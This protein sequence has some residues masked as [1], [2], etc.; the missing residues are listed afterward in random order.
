MNCKTIKPTQKNLDKY[1]KDIEKV[2][3]QY[4]ELNNKIN[5][6]KCTEMTW[7]KDYETLQ[8]TGEF[9]KAD[10]EFREWID[11]IYNKRRA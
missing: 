2:K 11:N 9:D 1:L 5:E 6:L 10:N 4:E 8:Y 3:K 7:D